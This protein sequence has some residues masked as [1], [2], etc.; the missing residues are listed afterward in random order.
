MDIKNKTVLVLGGWGLVGNA[1]T[2]K[3]VPENPKQI[4][5]TSLKKSEAED[6]CERLKLE[7][8]E[9]PN[10]YFI[11]WWGNIFVRNDFKDEDIEEIKQE[12]RVSPFISY[13][14]TLPPN[15][16]NVYRSTPN[17]LI[18][19][20]HYGYN[21][22][23]DPDIDKLKDFEPTKINIPFAG[24]LREEQQGIVDKYLEHKE[25]GGGIISIPQSADRSAQSKPTIPHS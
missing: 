6:E 10:D 5:V 8:P 17:Q 23:G 4:I 18:L 19:P 22:I 21:T 14:T 1:V 24:S 11:P 15:S 2:R 12:C 7:F 13:T 3:L 25:S 20:R 9:K 16:F